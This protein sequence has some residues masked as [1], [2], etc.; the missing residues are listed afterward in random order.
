MIPQNESDV[1]F[2][3]SVINIVI[4]HRLG[5]RFPNRGTKRF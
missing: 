3:R 1:I 2:Y 4:G 5:R